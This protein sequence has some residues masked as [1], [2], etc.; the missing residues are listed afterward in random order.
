MKGIGRILRP[1]VAIC[2]LALLLAGCGSSS[3]GDTTPAGTIDV[4]VT[5]APALNYD[6]VYVTVTKIAFHLRADA[7]F[8]TY[9]TNKAHGGFRTYSGNK[10]ERLG[11]WVTKDLP[12]PVTVDLAKLAN[13]TMY[14]DNNNNASLFSGISLSPGRYQQIRIFLASENS[15][16]ASASALGLKYNNEVQ[17]KGDSTHYPLHIPTSDEGI[18]LAPESPVVVTAGGKVKLALDFN[19]NNDVVEVNPNGA[20][21]F[22]LKPRLGYFDMNQVAKITGTVSFGNLSTSQFVIKAEQ[23]VAGKNYRVVRRITSVDKSTG[24]FKLNPL[25]VFGNATTASYDILL[26]GLKVQT[27]IV[28][29]VK[30]HKGGTVDLKTITMQSGTDFTAKLANPMHPS[31][32]WVNFYQTIAGDT[33]PF[34]VRYRHLN[35]YTGQFFKAIE[36]STGPIQVAT[37]DN[38]AGTVGAFAA[39]TTSQGVFTAVADAAGFYNQGASIP[40]ITGTAGQPPVSINNLPNNAPQVKSPAT[41]TTISGNIII[42]STLTGLT[43]GH[44]FITHG[45]LVID[46]Y[47]LSSVAPG[48]VPLPTG[49]TL[50]TGITTLTLPGGVAGAYYGVN[51]RAWGTNVRASGGLQHV[52]LTKATAITLSDITLK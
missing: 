13:G 48:S 50:P 40:G 14:A 4:D 9:S 39:D 32:A 33:V 26:R 37:F 7:G 16:A 35:P 52:D 45:G 42:P 29:G 15:L 46:S 30:V 28:K 20:K 49:L 18:K 5:D 47:D 34:E 6:H 11:S 25:P 19:L 10:V 3:P 21:E 12:A 43:K 8:R 24:G 17:L 31:G 51:V 2:S 1:A 44:L 36:L 38:T 22:I 23:V 27:A 41:A